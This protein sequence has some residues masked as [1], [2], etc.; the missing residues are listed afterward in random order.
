MSAQNATDASRATPNAHASTS[1]PT[2]A[3]A[4]PKK[5]LDDKLQPPSRKAFF[6]VAAGIFTLGFAGAAVYGA[7]KL[8][9]QQVAEA[10][11]AAAVAL[12]Q[13][14]NQQPSPPPLPSHSPLQASSPLKARVKTSSNGFD[15]GSAGTSAP[16]VLSRNPA[17]GNP[18]ASPSSSSS[19]SS[20][21]SALPAGTGSS[22]L[23]VH[24]QLLLEQEAPPVTAIKAFGAATAIVAITAAVGLEVSRRVFD[25]KDVSRVLN[26]ANRICPGHRADL[27]YWPFFSLTHKQMDDLSNRFRAFSPNSFPAVES[28]GSSLRDKLNG[29][30]PTAPQDELDVALNQ[31]Q[32]DEE[33]AVVLSEW[34]AAWSDEP[35][36]AESTS[37]QQTPAEADTADTDTN[38]EGRGGSSSRPIEA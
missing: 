36:A 27:T 1:K 33:T 21:P 15:W 18:I 25:I 32:S 4:Q 14:P 35:D 6:G 34:A 22:T 13:S 31:S 26:F 20:P 12:K 29:F 19:S 3:Q 23:S 37:M 30:L 2:Q 8:R 16:S 10:A 7:R 24:D 28:L 38:T 9:K 17:K 11:E 5:S